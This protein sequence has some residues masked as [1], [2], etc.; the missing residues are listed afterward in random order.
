MENNDVCAEEFFDATPD[1]QDISTP[2]TR[3]ITSMTASDDENVIFDHSIHVPRDA[4][5]R[6][7][8][9]SARL[10]VNKKTTPQ[11]ARSS[12]ASIKNQKETIEIGVLTAQMVTLTNAL[13]TLE[14]TARQQQSEITNLK[15]ENKKLLTQLETNV[16]S[17]LS[18]LENRINGAWDIREKSYAQKDDVEKMNKKIEKISDHANAAL[19]ATSNAE[20]KYLTSEKCKELEDNIKEVQSGMNTLT[21]EVLTVKQTLHSQ[22]DTTL[23]TPVR[24]ERRTSTED[25]V[26]SVI[27]S[28]GRNVDTP[29]KDD[30]PNNE[31]TPEKDITPEKDDSPE[32][33]HFASEDMVRVKTPYRRQW[34]D[35]DD[36]KPKQEGSSN[37]KKPPLKTMMYMDSNRTFLNP[38]GL[39]RNLSMIPC[40]DIDTLRSML[41]LENFADVGVVFIHTGVNDIDTVEG[42]EVAK[43]LINIVNKLH[44]LHPHLKVVLSEITPRKKFKDDQVKECNRCLHN[45]LRDADF[46]TIAKHSNLR[47]ER[48]TFHKDD[49]HL[50]EISIS[51]FAANIKN[52][53]R[54]CLGIPS[55]RSG[56][57]GDREGRRDKSEN[58]KGGKRY[59]KNN[60]GAQTK[61]NHNMNSFKQDLIR[62]LQNY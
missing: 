46:I 34:G 11:K 29:T 2:D 12:K 21:N 49:K 24:K 8:K 10:S 14:K 36:D 37:N 30:S 6:P 5:G 58:P 35:E 17:K 23:F 28:D 47:N 38:D 56:K 44:H 62:F 61:K 19:Q 9:R 39:W 43:G 25:L 1:I 26:P 33:D 20:K 7:P 16:E 15:E 59:M 18:T 55:K 60:N 31:D 41:E 51:L 22:E 48:M 32:M 52:A 50:T 42:E 54:S 13:Q 53:L 27:S 57:R 3:D 40:K 4:K 45:S